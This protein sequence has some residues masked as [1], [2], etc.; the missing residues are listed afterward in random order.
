MR[1]TY[2]TRA[3]L[4]DSVTVQLTPLGGMTT[5]TI[6]PLAQLVVPTCPTVVDCPDVRITASRTGLCVD[7][8]GTTGP[9]TYTAQIVSGM[10]PTPVAWTGPFTWSV[11]DAS[12]ALV[13]LPAPTPTGNTLTMAF[14]VPDRYTVTAT[15]VRA[16]GCDPV[17]LA[18]ATTVDVAR[19]GCPAIV[20][21]VLAQR[22]DRCSFDFS[23]SLTL[24]GNASERSGF[25]SV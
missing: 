12:G 22:V 21:G 7:A 13:P 5:T 3:M 25:Q 11:R 10:P 16:Q 19:C 23:A 8:N 4:P 24:S 6:L 9:V 20:G 1:S 18:G 14:T 15:I 2:T 17:I